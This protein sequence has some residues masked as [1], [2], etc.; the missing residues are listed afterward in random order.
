MVKLY[1]PGTRKGNRTWIAR[2]HVAGRQYEIATG[3]RNA[4]AARQ[5]WERFA[6]AV[7]QDRVARPGPLTFAEVAEAYRLARRPSR[8]ERRYIARLEAELGAR[9]IAELRPIDIAEAAARLYPEA[10]NETRN[11]QAYAPAAAILHFAAESGLRD[12][13]VIRKLPEREPEARRPAAGVPEI[14]LANTAGAERRLLVFLLHQGW[15][16]TETL[17]LDW[18]HVDLAGR[19]LAVYIAKSGRWKAVAMHDA[20]L[21]AL[22]AAQG[23]RAG[24][25]FPW[26]NRHQVYRWLKPLCRR[27]GVRFTPHM[28]RHSFGGALREAGATPRDLVDLS[29]WISEK[30]TARYQHAGADHARR[31]IARLAFGGPGDKPGESGEK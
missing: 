29:T 15:R 23:P 5:A 11:R 8:N 21:E 31:V 4:A 16:V 18:R 12:Y 22:A 30:S 1:R 10:R 25:V 7:R 9:A 20:T 14:L 19:T 26:R 3:A 6:A 2:G 24:R 17:S 27:L 28:A 13:L